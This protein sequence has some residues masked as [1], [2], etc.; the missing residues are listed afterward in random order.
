M[1]D[2][3]GDVINYIIA[4]HL[5]T[6]KDKDIFKDYSPKDPDSCICVYEYN[7]SAPALFT[8]MS[9]RSVQITVRAR[10]STEAKPKCWA[11]YKLLR[12]EDLLIQLGNRKCIIS[13][14]N[15]PLKIGVDEKQRV[16]WAFNLGITTN[17]D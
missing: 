3:L 8:D 13:T 12:K 16:I 15:T 9:V 11:L 17:F 10:N 2:L 7:G 5:A 6:K 4:G 14:R 1:G